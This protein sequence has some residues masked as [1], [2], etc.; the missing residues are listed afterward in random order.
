MKTAA[1]IWLDYG[2]SLNVGATEKALAEIDAETVRLRAALKPF[3]DIADLVDHTDVRDGETV[4]RLPARDGSRQFTLV[5]EDFRRAGEAFGNEQSPP[6]SV[7][8]LNTRPVGFRVKV[9]PAWMF[10]ANEDEARVAAE[11]HGTDYQGLYVRDGEQSSPPKTEP[12][13]EITY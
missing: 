3:A 8:K 13:G 10:I 1:Q 7:D 2:R 6:R 5:R 4:Y 11:N 12:T 9:G